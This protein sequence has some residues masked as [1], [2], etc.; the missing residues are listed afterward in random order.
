MGDVASVEGA[1]G[2]PKDLLCVHIWLRQP[3]CLNINNKGA[4][5]RLLWVDGQDYSES[6]HEGIAD[7]NSKARRVHV[8]ELMVVANYVVMGFGT[9]EG[10]APEVESQVS[11]DVSGEVIAADVVGARSKAAG[12]VRGVKPQILAADSCHDVSANLLLKG[13]TVDG[14]EIIENRTVFLN[15]SNIVDSS[16][17]CGLDSTGGSFAAQAEEVLDMIDSTV[18]CAEYDA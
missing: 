2:F 9:N 17:I 5:A 14:V 15:N 16:A 10:V 11:P 18:G 8:I 4:F 1:I 12:G 7:R 3:L 6:W 13:A